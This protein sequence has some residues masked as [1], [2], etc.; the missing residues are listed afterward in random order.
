MVKKKKASRKELM[1]QRAKELAKKGRALP[2]FTIKEGTTR[3]RMPQIV[4]DQ[5]FCVE[6]IQ[7][8]LGKDIG[9][10]ISAASF[11]EPCPIME[12]YQKLKEGDE[13]D[14]EVAKKI[15]PRRR[16]LGPHYRFK[17]EKGKEV[18][19]EAGVKLTI[20]TNA[21]YQAIT[22]MYLDDEYGDF[23]DPLQG[24]DFKYKRT[25]TGQMDTEYS[26]L[27]CKATKIHPEFR[28]KVY[29]PEEMVREL[30]PTY[31]EAEVKL[32]QF[33]GIEEEDEDEA[34]KKKKKKKSST[35]A[36]K[37]KKKKSSKK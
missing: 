27:A 28:K 4:E 1:E 16:Y 13:D 37:K 26:V 35:E 6:V 3:M 23:T 18:D 17:D 5:E 32:N 7:F 36:P 9:G 30:I 8:F 20:L 21:I 33:L 10:V 14:K 2:F 25:G 12:L 29:N 34:P 15:Y 31:E 19:L 22:D 24:Y 11:G